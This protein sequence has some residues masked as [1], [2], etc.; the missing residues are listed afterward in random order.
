MIPPVDL[1]LSTI[2][3]ALTVAVL[4]AVAN[5]S[6]REEAALGA[7]TTRW[8]RDVVDHVADAE[9]ASHRDCRAALED[10]VAIAAGAAGPASAEVVRKAREALAGARSEAIAAARE[11]TRTAKRLL[12]EALRAARTDGEGGIATAIRARLATLAAREIERE[13]AFTR[14]TGLDPDTATIRP[15]AEVVRGQR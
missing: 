1:L 9:R 8:L 12:A 13:R 3:R 6:A 15:L 2:E 11:E 10:V 14:A 5:A 4:P 7:L